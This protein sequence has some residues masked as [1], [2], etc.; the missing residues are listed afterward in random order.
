M[1]MAIATL[2]ETETFSLE[3]FMANPTDHQEWVDGQLVEKTG[4]T[5]KHIVLQK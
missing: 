1:N 4:M 5:I 3:D 2:T